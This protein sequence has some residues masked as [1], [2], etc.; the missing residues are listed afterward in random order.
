MIVINIISGLVAWL[1]VGFLI[2]ICGYRFRG[3]K[4]DYEE[5]ELTLV[6][7]IGWPIMLTCWLLKAFSKGVKRFGRLAS[8][9]ASKAAEGKCSN[10]DCDT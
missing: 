1:A 6:G 3:W 4:G 9:Q 5:T 8:A 7:M 10:C 2:V